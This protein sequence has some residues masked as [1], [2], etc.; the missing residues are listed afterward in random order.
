MSAGKGQNDSSSRVYLAACGV[1]LGAGIVSLAQRLQSTGL[2]DVR[3]ALGL[4]FDEG[5]W[6]STAF[7]MALMFMG[8]FSVFL[9]G[10]L[11]P[12]RVLLCSGA[13]FTIVAILLPLVPDLQAL[14][15][16][17]VIA[18]LAA[19]TFYPLSLSYALRILPPRYAIYTV[20]A[21]SMELLS[22]LSIGTPLEGWFVEH[23]S[24]RWVFWTGAALTPVMM[25]CIYLA[26][27]P[28]PKPEG[29]RPRLSWRGFLFA[30]LGLSLILGALEQGERLDW[31]GSGT[32]NA[33]FVAAAVLLLAAAVHRWSS[34]NPMVDLGFLLKQNTLIIGAGLFV[35]R[36]L[37]LGILVLIPGYL[38][39]VQGYRPE[40]TGRVLLWLAIPVLV[41]GVCAANLM[42]R[43]HPRLFV[44]V[45][46][47]MVAGACLMD[48]NLDSA[49]AADQFW[50]SQLVMA[51]GLAFYFVGEIGTIVQ[52]ALEVGAM[53][54]PIKT[55]TYAAYFQTIRLFGGQVGTTL[56][57]RFIFVRST[58][59]SSVLARSVKAGH[60][61]TD[62][63]LRA[64]VARLLPK[65]SGAAEA[66]DRAAASLIGELSRQAHT[67]T[68]QD[69]FILVAWFCVGMLVLLVFLKPMKNYFDER[70]PVGPPSSVGGASPLVATHDARSTG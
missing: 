17:Q 27:P 25:I 12:R 42:R 16:L 65:S 22:T 23:W 37:L 67:L 26:V 57:Q 18:G 53:S 51:S 33:M 29:P 35:L 24:W 31:F 9:G 59:H 61:L 46:L 41:M 6:I 55:M 66:Q 34:P 5:A 38:G 39:T 10:L 32:I 4:G 43:I 14:I 19:G 36:F 54:S 70:R 63:R 44:A 11:G 60:Y 15:V 47:T 62:E 58:F 48:A 1:F 49:W 69:G 50:W 68:Y 21:Y 45:A 20:G 7:D 2:P 52:N 13:V 30:S 56:M 64:L 28:A 40:Q 3:G 8:P